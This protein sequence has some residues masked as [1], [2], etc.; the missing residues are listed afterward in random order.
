MANETSPA[1]APEIRHTTIN[2]RKLTQAAS[3]TRKA[4]GV[5]RIMSGI[6]RG[7]PWWEKTHAVQHE[8]SK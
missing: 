6:V 4:I 5:P 7:R 3:M 2:C 1:S 8:Q